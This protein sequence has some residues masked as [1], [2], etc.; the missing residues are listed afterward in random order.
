MQA[1]SS[2]SHDLLF[3]EEFRTLVN[4]SIPCKMYKILSVGVF[5]PETLDILA[6]RNIDTQRVDEMAH[7]LHCF[8]ICL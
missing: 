8:K 1:K 3:L 2:K 7:Q 6:K 4:A 5:F